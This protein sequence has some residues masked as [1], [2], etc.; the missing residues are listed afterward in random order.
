MAYWCEQSNS[1]APIAKAAHQQTNWDTILVD[2]VYSGLTSRTTNPIDKARLL[3]AKSVHSGDWLHAAPITSV[4]LRMSNEVVRVAVGLRL[5]TALCEPHTCIC[6]AAVDARGLHGLSCKKVSGKQQR[7][8]MIT[9]VVWRACNRAGY[10]AMKEP[11]GLARTDGRRPD[12]VTIIPW[13]RGQC[14]VWDVT[15]SD[16]FAQSY[17]DHSSQQA[18]AAAD[19]AVALK[20]AKYAD[21]MQSHIFVPVALESS[22]CWNMPALTFMKDHG[23][24]ITH[25]MGDLRE[26]SYLLQRLSVALQRGNAVSILGTFDGY[27][28]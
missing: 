1:A 11:V 8:S 19:R 21:L 27:A 17:L 25:A 9:D 10:Q 23:K 4:G 7:H 20:N 14:L 16:T 22:G 5:G 28:T 2:N 3:A 13:S 18:G 15:I 24:R 6:G 12:G 26:T